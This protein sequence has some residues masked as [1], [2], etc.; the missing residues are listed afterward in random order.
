LSIKRNR[1]VADLIFR[2]V[3]SL[4]KTKAND[5]RL[6]II[7]VTF[8]DLSPDLSYA[9]IYYMLGSSIP[10]KEIEQ[11]LKKAGGFIRCQ[12]AE[13]LALRYVPKL[14]FRY[15]HPLERSRRLISLIKEIKE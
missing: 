13:R 8:V 4:L 3:A 6:K 15:D 10:N 11:A 7:N 12:L 9:T 1:Q 5:P 2:E 14:D